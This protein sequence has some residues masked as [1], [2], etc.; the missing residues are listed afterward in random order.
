MSTSSPSPPSSN[1]LR[2]AEAEPVG[3]DHVVAAKPV[4]GDRVVEIEVLDTTWLA[5]PSITSAPLLSESR[6]TSSP[7]GAIDD[8]RVGRAV[9]GRGAGNGGEVDVDLRHVGAA[10]VVDIDR[11][12]A[13]EGIE[14]MFS[15]P[16]MSIVTVATS[17]VNS[18]ARRWPK[19]LMFSAMLA[20]LNSSVSMPA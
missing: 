18:R 3:H 12:G 16:F 20:P 2:P 4:D 15:T 8:D 10:H 13:A 1:E 11:V 17:R 5:R 14:V 7:L 6:M 9:A 19:M